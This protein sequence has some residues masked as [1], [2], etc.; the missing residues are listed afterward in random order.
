MAPSD[1]TRLFTRKNPAG[2][3]SRTPIGVAIGR[4]DFPRAIKRGQSRHFDIYSDPVLGASGR[5][6]ASSTLERC[7]HDYKALKS[8]FGDFDPPGTPFQVII[9]DLHGRPYEQIDRS[10][11]CFDE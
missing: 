8:W 1:V 9:T 10:H 2:P 3:V 4:G 5:A 7:E 11:H 6:I